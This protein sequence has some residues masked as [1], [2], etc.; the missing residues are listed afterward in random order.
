MRIVQILHGSPPA[1]MGG[2]GLYVQALSTALADLGHT[3]AIVAPGPAATTT[4]GETDGVTLYT[5]PTPRPKRWRDTWDHNLLPWTDWLGEY[6]PDVVHIHH[7]SA[8]P[9]GLVAAID[10]RTVLTLH[11]YA[12]PCARGQM[13]TAALKS[14]NGPSPLSCTQCLGPALNSNP[15]KA[16]IGRVLQRIPPVYNALRSRANRPS[17]EPHS[18]VADRLEAAQAA[19]EAADVLLSPSLDLANRVASM[20]YRRPELTD[21]PLLQTP[22]PPMAPSN[23]PVR[24]LFASSI[25]PTK[26]PDR[27]LAAFARLNGNSELTIAGHTPHFDGHPGF[28]DALKIAAERTPNVQWLGAVPSL[29]VPA[30]MAQH[31]VLLLPSIWPENSP[32]VVREATAAGMGIIAC[33]IGG[34]G[35]L[36]PNAALISTDAELLQAMASAQRMGRVRHPMK[37][38]P[39]PREHAK[40]LL[41]ARYR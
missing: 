13:V 18:D 40:A 29:S 15:L 41:D 5:I 17:F 20:G 24:F 27:A 30:L 19:I 3:I 1:S 34:V 31:D 9:L 33:K 6:K 12:I 11:D 23:G 28:G 16:T 25:I 38:W 8:I 37:L 2:T 21:L 4:L 35:E 39:N 7:L 32:L 22:A 36:A 10:C 14:C 26:G